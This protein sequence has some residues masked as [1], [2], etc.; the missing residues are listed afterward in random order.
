MQY[1]GMINVGAASLIVGALAFVFVF[2]YLAANFNYPDIL[3][4]SA[5]E[6]LPR[7]RDGGVAMRAVWA[8]YAFLPLFLVPGAVAAYFACPS[9]RA[10]MTL[11]L[12]VASMGALAMCLGLMR[13]PSIHWALAEAYSQ[14]GSETRMSLDAVFSGM[15]LYIGN[16]I[17]EFLGETMLAAFFM[18]SGSSMLAEA[19]FPRWFGWSG[20]VFAFLFLV[21]A[22]RNVTNAVQVVAD[23]NNA[24]LPFWM[25]V[26]GAG[27]IWFSGRTN[28]VKRSSVA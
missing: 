2:S 23:I 27:L 28:S 12:V 6:V 11:A 26:M 8:V 10:R 9:S 18:L 15:N 24:L 19:R 16:Y 14:A 13:W 1:R 20:V 4:G 22:F 3:A 17:G 5:A 21:G 7:L 25:I